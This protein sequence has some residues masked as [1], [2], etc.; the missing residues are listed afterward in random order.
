MASTSI[1]VL[2]SIQGNRKT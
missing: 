2:D 1:Y